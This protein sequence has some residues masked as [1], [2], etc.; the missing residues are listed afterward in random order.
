MS[1]S[2]LRDATKKFDK[3]FVPTSPLTPAMRARWNRAKRKKGR[4]RIGEGATS[5]LIFIERGLLKDV[6]AFT[7]QRGLSRSQLIADSLRT[8]MKSLS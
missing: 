3:D 1:T 8:V 7:E 4:P 5:V 6:D 2:E